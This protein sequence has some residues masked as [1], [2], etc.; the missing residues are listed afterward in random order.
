MLPEE[1][2]QRR[3]SEWTNWLTWEPAFIPKAPHQRRLGHIKRAWVRSALDARSSLLPLV[4]RGSTPIAALREQRGRAA[5]VYVPSHLPYQRARG[6][7]RAW[8]RRSASGVCSSVA[9][10]CSGRVD[11]T[12]AAPCLLAAWRRP[13]RPSMRLHCH[14]LLDI[15][16]CRRVSR[17]RYVR[18]VSEAGDG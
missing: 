14:I 7:V 9:F 10:S 16:S 6:L 4:S 15:V 18:R 5:L 3:H 12:T 17:T 8:V 1:V 11:V 13:K 2:R